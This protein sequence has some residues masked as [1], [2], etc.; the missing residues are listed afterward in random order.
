MKISKREFTATGNQTDYQICF[1]LHLSPAAL[2][3]GL[4]YR[5]DCIK[6]RW[7]GKG[8]W[9]KW[10]HSPGFAQFKRASRKRSCLTSEVWNGSGSNS[11]TVV[12]D[13]IVQLLASKGVDEI[14]VL[15]VIS[16]YIA[17]L[18]K[19]VPRALTSLSVR[20]SHSCRYSMSVSQ[21]FICLKVNIL[22]F[23]VSDNPV[24][25]WSELSSCFASDSTTRWTWDQSDSI[26]DRQGW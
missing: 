7:E 8:G 9:R 18:N 10:T 25:P 22:D 17:L 11:A 1:R 24:A 3:D 13:Q 20:S 21:L 4:L 2:W 15:M 12:L 19:R 14:R 16:W 6:R 23:L 5:L 26:Q